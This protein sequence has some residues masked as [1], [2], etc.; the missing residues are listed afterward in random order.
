MKADFG[1]DAVRPKSANTIPIV[2]HYVRDYLIKRFGQQIAEDIKPFEIQKW[3][4][5]LNETGGLAW[6]TVAKMRGL[7]HR[8]Y[9]VG[10]LHEH[11][12]KNP[13]MH[14]ETR[15]KSTYRQS[16]SSRPRPWRF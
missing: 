6:T 4:K 15:S 14:V 3:L 5:A 10:I 2:E 11:V 8:I 7:M 1:A 13:V 9:K 12:A 16:S